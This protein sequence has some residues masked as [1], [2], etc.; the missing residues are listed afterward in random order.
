MKQKALVNWLKV[1]IILVGLCGAFFFFVFI[2][3]YG[4]S[5]VEDMPEFSYCYY[6]WLFFLWGASIPCFIVLFLGWKIT[7]NIGKDNS[8]CNE[9][10]K[11]CKWI[12]WFTAADTLYF[13]IGNNVLLFANMNH[14]GIL[15]FSLI[16]IFGGICVTVAAAMLSHLVQKAADLQADNDLTI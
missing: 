7:S 2:P 16:V 9:N 14:P 15:L 10:A 5:L 13:F 12:S 4:C 8:F 11:Y 1:L 3:K 6:P